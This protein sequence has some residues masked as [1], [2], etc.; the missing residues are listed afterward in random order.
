MGVNSVFRQAD[1]VTIFENAGCRPR[2]LTLFSAGFTG[3]CPAVKAAAHAAWRRASHSSG[4][5]LKPA[6]LFFGYIDTKAA[7]RRS[8]YITTQSP[9]LVVVFFWS[10]PSFPSAF[11]AFFKFVSFGA[12]FLDVVFVDVIFLDD[13]ILDA[14]FLGGLAVGG[15]LAC[16]SVDIQETMSPAST[17][18]AT[19]WTAPLELQNGRSMAHEAD[20]SGT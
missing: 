8:A 12:A 7:T 11:G 19:T 1:G 9:L 16:V 17:A 10:T 5:A 18:S 20:G 2:R 6:S 13:V 15:V 3:S 4:F 14:V